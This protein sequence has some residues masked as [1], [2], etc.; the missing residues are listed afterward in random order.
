MFTKDHSFSFLVNCQQIFS[1]ELYKPY[2]FIRLEY[3]CASVWKFGIFGWFRIKIWWKHIEEQ[4]FIFLICLLLIG[5]WKQILCESLQLWFSKILWHLFV[6]DFQS[7]VKIIV[8][9]FVQVPFF[10]LS[11]YFM[12]LLLFHQMLTVFYGIDIFFNVFLV[13]NEG[14]VF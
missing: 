12:T 11:F 10:K 2:F 6:E 7:W 9:N 4:T 13:S 5:R 3:F 1:T 14:L 8:G